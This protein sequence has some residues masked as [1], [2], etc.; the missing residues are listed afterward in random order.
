M[1]AALTIVL[2]LA[3]AAALLLRVAAIA[4]PLG[5]DQSLWASAVRA[6]ARGQHLY[7]DVWEQRPPGIYW[8]YLAAFRAL[9]WSPA[10]VAWLD[11]AASAATTLLVF[12]IARSLSDRLTAVLAAALYA[13]LTIPAGLY[14]YGGFLERSVCETF[15]PVVAGIGAWSA[16]KL[17]DRSLAATAFAVGMCAG[18]ATV[19]KPNAGL[20]LAPLLLWSL[21]YGDRFRSRHALVRASA[22][23]AAAAAVLPLIAILWLASQGGLHDAK[24]AVI[25]FN[26]FYVG[27]GFTATAIAVGFAKGVWLRIKTDPLWMAGSVASLFAAIEFVRRRRLPPLP[28]LAMFWGATAAVVIVVNGVRLYNSYFIQ[29]C[30]PLALMAAWFLGSATP[31]LRGPAY[32]PGSAMPDLRG[33]AY[34]R[35]ARVTTVALMGLLLVRGNYIG[36]T[37]ESVALDLRALNGRLGA[38]D[39]LDRFGGYATGRGYSARANVELASYVA[40]HT[41]ADERVFV[42]GISGA[43]L[44]FDAD[45][46]PA[47]RFLRVNF[48]VATDFPDPQFRLEPVI[49]ALIA[50]RPRYVIFE[51]NVSSSPVGAEVERLTEH[52]AVIRMLRGY[53]FETTIEDFALYRRTE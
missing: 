37:I 49:D 43:G 42:F 53:Q 48:F 51:R 36:R 29:A 20:Y 14:R 7:Q 32:V 47:H 16:V 18:A 13:A 30:A 39:Y 21:H 45:R 25:D 24:V 35:A 26:R 28:A 41:S 10:A 11:I 4:E 2:A 8:T 5:I 15:V 3:A 33:P 40:S 17:K 22:I 19:Y 1:K 6:M 38:A 52:P 50:R 34:V 44:Y 46:L 23:A 27:Q 31:D 12:A 9:R